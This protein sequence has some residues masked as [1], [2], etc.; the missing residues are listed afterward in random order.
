MKSG[1]VNT[2]NKLMTSISF[3]SV[4]N[5]MIIFL[6]FKREKISYLDQK[7][8][9]IFLLKKDTPLKQYWTTASKVSLTS[10][11]MKHTARK[12]QSAERVP[13]RITRGQDLSYSDL[14]I[15]W[16]TVISTFCSARAFRE[17]PCS[18]RLSGQLSL[19]GDFC[20]L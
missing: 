17:L 1:T 7:K 15:A 4:T 20:F 10:Y 16:A 3:F 12:K 14:I 18:L 13:H 5:Q 2:L 9:N 11:L 19:T 6:N 8:R